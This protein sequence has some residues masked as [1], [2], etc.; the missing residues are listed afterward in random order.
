MESGSTKETTEG[1]E[2]RRSPADKLVESMR[3]LVRE[4]LQRPSLSPAPA[5][6]LPNWKDAFWL[7]IF[8]A[9][10]VLL[11]SWFPE[12]AKGPLE[13]LGKFLPWLLGGLFVAANDWFRDRLLEI[14]RARR[15][16][17]AQL[18]FLILG[19]TFGRI[20]IPITPSV[21]PA[22][23]HLYIDGQMRASDQKIWLTIR[24]HQ[25]K[26]SEGLDPS[27]VLAKDREFR[28]SWWQILSAPFHNGR[29]QEWSLVYSLSV[30]TPKICAVTITKQDGAFDSEF[31]EAVHVE[32]LRKRNENALE[33][34][35]FGPEKDNS[36]ELPYGKYVAQAAGCRGKSF[37][38]DRSHVRDG[39]DLRP[40]CSQ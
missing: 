14:S 4:E 40:E 10:V 16:R 28:L 15:L 29:R 38:V 19:L 12:E 13:F 7:A 8:I 5:P 9:D 18:T 37:T 11:F 30:M 6:K 33:F 22:E 27:D 31:L 20:E 26:V 17:A 2:N 24:N 32:K 23:A 35:S 36:I 1:A 34:Q 21:N 39:L 25:V 3:D